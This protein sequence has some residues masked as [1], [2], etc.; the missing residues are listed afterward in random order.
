LVEAIVPASEASAVEVLAQALGYLR[1]AERLEPTKRNPALHVR[2]GGIHTHAASRAHVI[3]AWLCVH[4]RES[5][6]PV[7]RRP[8][9]SLK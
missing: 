9:A 4:A 6:L 3:R 8:T 7:S 2:V 1:R 5:R